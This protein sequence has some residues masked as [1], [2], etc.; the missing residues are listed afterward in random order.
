MK[1]KFIFERFE[2]FLLSQRP[3]NE[4]KEEGTPLDE[5]GAEELVDK[6]IELDVKLGEEYLKPK[7]KNK[8]A[9]KYFSIYAAKAIEALKENKEEDAVVYSILS[10]GPMPSV[11]DMLTKNG[12]SWDKKW[13]TEDKMGEF[14]DFADKI[15][16]MDREE[17]RKIADEAIKNWPPNASKGAIL[18]ELKT[19]ILWALL[20]EEERKKVYQDFYNLA[21]KRGYETTE[22]LSK[23]IDKNYSSALKETYRLV[24]PGIIVSLVKE[25]S[26]KPYPSVPSKTYLI[27]NEKE[28][29]VFK[30]NKTGINGQSDFMEDSFQEIVNNLGSIFDRYKA[31]Q[32]TSIKKINILTSADRYR[33]QY[34]AEKLSWGELSYAR[35]IA[36]SKLIEGVARAVGIDDKVIAEFP[37]ITTIYAK[38]SNGDGTSGPNPPE[39]KKFGYYVEGPKGVQWIDGKDRNSVVIV[40]INEEGTPT[41]SDAKNAKTVSMPP[42]ASEADYNEFRYNNIEIEFEMVDPSKT[43]EFSEKVVDLKYPVK[44]SIPNRYNSKSIKIALPSITKSY[45][46][47]G[48]NLGG[49]CPSFTETVKTK[50]G[51]TFK[52]INVLTYKSDLTSK[53]F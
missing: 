17:V 4:K 23:I 21:T 41:A 15:E 34:E 2:E 22:S 53:L 52:T 6:I 49:R 25:E 31:G 46:S 51:L 44:I 20:K 11:I 43:F 12:M 42:E 3:L 36:M 14:E 1:S 10:R 8:E 37:S 27:A 29:E 50:Y 24:S 32:I 45:S 35:A 16:E 9:S 28:S 47:S 30:P 40:P 38:G 26:T 19:P 13:S 7:I 33:N 48:K 5:S 39:G 18:S